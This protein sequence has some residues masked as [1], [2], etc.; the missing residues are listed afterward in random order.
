MLQRHLAGEEET[1]W[2]KT[3]KEITSSEMVIFFVGL[4]LSSAFLAHRQQDV[5]VPC[6]WPPEKGPLTMNR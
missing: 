6:D 2:G 5:F 1:H 4:V 3:N